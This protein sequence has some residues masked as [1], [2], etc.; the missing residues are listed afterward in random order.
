MLGGADLTMVPEAD[1]YTQILLGLLMPDGTP[2]TLVRAPDSNSIHLYNEDL[3]DQVIRTPDATVTAVHNAR[4]K[5][6]LSIHLLRALGV[7][8]ILIRKNE[9]GGTLSRAD[10]LGAPPGHRADA[11]QGRRLQA[12]WRPGSSMAW[13]VAEKGSG[14][15]SH[16]R[17]GGGRVAG[18]GRSAAARS[19]ATAR[20]SRRVL[21]RLRS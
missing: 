14:R 8:E 13:A 2:L 7:D 21:R 6:S 1:G 10:R 20:R 12:S 3:H 17:P 18:R 11:G 16:I 4:S 5:N 15:H 19:P 9:A